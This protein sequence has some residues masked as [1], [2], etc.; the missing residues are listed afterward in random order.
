MAG[1]ANTMLLT[2]SAA[3]LVAVVVLAAI[4]FSDI[5]DSTALNERLGD[6]RWL[7]VLDADDTLVR[8]QVAAHRG[9]V[10]EAHTLW[11]VSPG[12]TSS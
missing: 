1:T 7:R 3:E 8:R 2:V 10:A 12:Q 9:H 5:E 4:F 11:A 6:Q